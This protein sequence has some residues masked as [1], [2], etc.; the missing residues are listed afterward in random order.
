MDFKTL[1]GLKIKYIRTS[2]ELTQE[3]F[4]SRIGIT[5]DRSQLARYETGQVFPSIELI[6]AVCE[7]YRV[8]S[9]WLLDLNDNKGITL[10][11][12]N[13]IYTFR[14]LPKEAQEGFKSVFEAL[15]RD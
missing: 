9:S 8:S 15:A 14:K 11:E 6:K 10:D 5:L 13:M 12:L 7:T 4:I 3:E 2:Q 1:I